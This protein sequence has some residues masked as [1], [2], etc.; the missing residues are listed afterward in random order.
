MDINLL[1]PGDG[2]KTLIIYIFYREEIK[3][4]KKKKP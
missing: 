4:G 3:K 2:K 1:I